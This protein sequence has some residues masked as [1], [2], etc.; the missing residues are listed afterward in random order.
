MGCSFIAV[1]EINICPVSKKSQNI[2]KNMGH[3]TDFY[4]IIS[5]DLGRIWEK[6][7]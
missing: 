3:I 1:E 6:I 2:F 4:V 7:I 5:F